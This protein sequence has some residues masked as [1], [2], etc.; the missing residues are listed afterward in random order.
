MAGVRKHESEPCNIASLIRPLGQLM[1]CVLVRMTSSD[2]KAA[3]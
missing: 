1:F 3:R 2:G